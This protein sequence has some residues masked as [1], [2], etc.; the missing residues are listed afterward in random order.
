MKNNKSKSLEN[1]EFEK[2]K[3]SE[4]LACGINNGTGT[5]H[6][7]VIQLFLLFFYTDVMQISAGYVAVLFLVVR[8]LDAIL[9][10][11]FGI[12]MDKIT[13][14]W[15]KYKPWLV[16]VGALMGI[17]GFLSFTSFN[18]E[19]TGKIVYITITYVLYSIFLSMIGAPANAISPVVTKRI[20]DRLSMGQIGYF[21]IM[22]GAL[23][24]QIG[25]QPLYKALGAGND[26]KGFSIVMGIAM[27]FSI[28]IAV[29]QNFV[30]RER[31]ISQPKKGEK[32]PSFKKMLAAVLSNKTALIVYAFAFSINIAN[33][34]RNGVQIFYFKYYFNNDMLVTVSGI[35]A[36]LPTLI[37]VLLSSK[38]TKLVG[39]K[40]NLVISAVVSILSMA[41]VIILPPTSVGVVVYL[42]TMA[43]MGF[44]TG[45]AN[46][47]QGT[48]MPA[49]ID[50]T[51]WK[52]GMNI[53]GF[54]SSFQGFLQT[55]AT[56]LSG[57]IA[58]GA[59]SVFGYVE[60]AASQSSTTIFGLKV[61]MSIIP[62][63][64]SVLTLSVVWF[65]LTESKQATITKELAERRKAA[66]EIA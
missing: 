45:L 23:L 64:F 32:G 24:A 36:L 4:K 42:T 21:T 6:I 54:M 63:V 2:I 44:F 39:I 52:T 20:E 10:P 34:L 62:A 43:F 25:V 30:I 59:L 18:F 46:P 3:F 53:N 28:V 12:M 11:F 61:I 41:V 47:A 65:D 60:G 31:Y 33:G 35:V 56:A 14:P 19:S 66:E 15:G 17:F 55:L 37:G 51:E 38:F 49:A 40:K 58:A 57:A 8:I 1:G 26:A 13:T 50:Y 29:W 48:M 16:W 5:F 27:V 22:I 7:Q 9:T